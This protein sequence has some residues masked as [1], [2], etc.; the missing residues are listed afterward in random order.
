MNSLGLRTAKERLKAMD[1]KSILHI[2]AFVG[3]SAFWGMGN[4]MIALVW[5]AFFHGVE[6][7]DFLALSIF[8]WQL[9]TLSA[10]FAA[11]NRT[12]RRITVTWAILFLSLFVGFIVSRG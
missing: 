9:F 6:R 5:R 4:V 1:E 2:Y 12:E 10:I 7:W 11:L 3:I 8:C